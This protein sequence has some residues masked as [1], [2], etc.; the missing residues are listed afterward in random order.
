MKTNR[1]FDF[2]INKSLK[3]FCTFKI[4]GDAKYLFVAKTTKGLK[5][6]VAWCLK[7]NVKF[8]VIGCGANLLFDDAGFNGA[9]IVNKTAKVKIRHHSITADSGLTISELIA[10]AKQ[11]NLSGLE[12]FTLI[13]SSVG[14]AV[15][16]NLGAW[17][18]EIAGLIKSVKGFFKSNVK[19]SKCFKSHQC[20]FGYRTSVFKTKQFKNKTNVK[21]EF[22]ITKVKFNLKKSSTSEIDEEIM[23]AI[24]KK[25]S[26]QPTDRPSAGSIFLR[27]NVIPAKLIDEAGL[28]GLRVGE[29]EISKKHS[30]F[31]INLGNAS[32]R[33]VKLLINIIQNEIYAR[34]S[35]T[36]TPEIEIVEF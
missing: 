14:G 33:D 35:A 36:L 12:N 18:C 5:K 27:S 24:T 6:S 19:R 4:G 13:P 26:T 15:I 32:S 17:G 31:I 9:I 22:I 23:A 2:F 11:K 29:A 21:D 34:Y 28:K 25:T 20:N 1:H 16:N 8:K 7:N 30:G 10:K 3:D